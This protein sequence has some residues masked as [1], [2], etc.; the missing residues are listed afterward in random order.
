M[1]LELERS[2]LFTVFKGK[3]KAR[4]FAWSRTD[5]IPSGCGFQ[6]APSQ[7]LLTGL[8]G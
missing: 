5:M 4:D 3:F 1:E 2:H 8:I 7:F 6:E